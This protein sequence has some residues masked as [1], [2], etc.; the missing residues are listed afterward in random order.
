MMLHD[1]HSYTILDVQIANLPNSSSKD[2]EYYHYG[3][4]LPEL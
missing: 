1:A 2:N 3:V 4:K